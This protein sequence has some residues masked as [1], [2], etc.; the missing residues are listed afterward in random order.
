[1][2][3]KE[4]WKYVSPDSYHLTTPQYFKEEEN[5]MQLPPLPKSNEIPKI[6]KRPPV[7]KHNRIPTASKDMD[8]Y[9]K[10]L[11]Q[12]QFNPRSLS[13]ENKINLAHELAS[14]IS[15]SD[16]HKTSDEVNMFVDGDYQKWLDIMIDGGNSAFNLNHEE[17]RINDFIESFVKTI[18]E[19]NE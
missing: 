17:L 5:D 10:L 1:M 12:Y 16:D 19:P 3:G 2:D 18:G 4:S 11:L 13:V 8:S 14:F 15:D 6:I 9:I 7:P